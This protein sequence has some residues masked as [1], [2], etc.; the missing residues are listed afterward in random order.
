MDGKRN[1]RPISLLRTLSKVVERVVL[2]R[3]LHQLEENYLLTERQH[4]LVDGKLTV[5]ASLVDVVYH[6]TEKTKEGSNVTSVFLDLC[7]AFDCLY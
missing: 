2:V 6:L 4:G 3:L 7:K 1:Y 5:T